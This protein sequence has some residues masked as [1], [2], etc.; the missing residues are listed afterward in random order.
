MQGDDAPRRG[1]VPKLRLRSFR[2]LDVL[3]VASV[4][5][6]ALLF[7]ALATFDYRQA[8]ATTER[9]LLVTLDT[10]HGHA[11]KVLEFQVLTLGAVEERLRGQS[12]QVVAANTVD[13]HSYLRAL[14]LYVEP[15]GI[16]VFGADGRVLAD[17][18]NEQPLASV[19][20][21]ER[22]YFRWHRDHPGP[23]P[24]VVG[25][26]RSRSSNQVVF[27]VTRRRSAADG[28]FLGVMAVGVQ[29]SSFL[30]YWRNAA[31]VPDALIVLSQSDGLVLARWP[32][33]EPGANLRLPAQGPL[34]QAFNADLQRVVVQG[35]SPVNG[36]DSLLAYR[37]LGRFPVN[38]AVGLPREATL[39]PWYRRLAIYGG[40]ALVISLAL[41]WL[42]LVAQRRTREL[43]QLN[44]H[45]EERVKERTA[46]IQA[47]EVQVRL[48]ARE[49]DHRAK[50]ALAVVQA[51]LQLTPKTDLDT[52]V[53]AVAGRVSALARAQT[54]LS[55]NQWRG[56]SLQAL[57][58]AELTPFVSEAGGEFNTRAELDGLAVLLPPAAAQPLA[59]AMHE[60]ATN[61]LKHGALSVPGGQATVSWHLSDT[62]EA[63]GD[64]LTLRWEETKGPPTVPPTRRGFGFRMLEAIVR[65]QLG[66]RLSLFWLASG[67]VCE[68]EMSLARLRK[69]GE[70]GTLQKAT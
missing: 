53:Q 34:A 60:L 52:Y 16:T 7:G 67:L 46:A 45:L 2:S 44:A 25:L 69:G 64:L 58:K 6:P 48:L 37:R 57:L 50:N 43:S 36:I 15:V 22:E 20:V 54:L 14:S 62:E 5:L 26:L 47:S 10:L 8:L 63:P 17:S 65:G 4:L 27:F 59:M 12:N 66:G 35:A 1:A 11:E 51:T 68:I 41:S 39:A 19:N 70:E 9:D 3:L 21:S 29:Q 23:E 42:C 24:H 56:A 13:H 31:A 38:I 30:E 18:M 49:V 28:S 33:I 61:A 32:A 40:F 55:Q